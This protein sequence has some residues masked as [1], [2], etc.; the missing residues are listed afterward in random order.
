MYDP[1]EAVLL[2]LEQDQ[3][4][5]LTVARKI[6]TKRKKRMFSSKSHTSLN[7]THMYQDNV[8]HDFDESSLRRTDSCGSLDSHSHRFDEDVSQHSTRRLSDSSRSTHRIVLT[9]QSF[10]TPTSSRGYNTSG[11]TLSTDFMFRPI[12]EGRP[13]TA[14]EIMDSSS[15]RL[16]Y[17]TS[18]G[19]APEA[20]S[21]NYPRIQYPV[22]RHKSMEGTE[23]SRLQGPSPSPMK[24]RSP[25]PLKQS[26]RSFQYHSQDISSVPSTRRDQV[27]PIERLA[28]YRSVSNFKCESL[29]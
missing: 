19:S 14:G 18:L 13:S 26:S 9:G 15:R 10:Q 1:E 4:I 29:V 7:K 6:K 17:S 25:S 8:F 24:Y 23:R 28:M 11:E 22:V 2:F 27:A 16:R 5:S 3:D 12:N 21:T 20:S